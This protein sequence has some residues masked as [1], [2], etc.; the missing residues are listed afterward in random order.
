MAGTASS[1]ELPLHPDFG[2]LAR[3]CRGLL[4]QA[5]EQ[6]IE[7]RCLPIGRRLA[8]GNQPLR[9][10]T[11]R[12]TESLHMDCRS[13]QDYPSR[14]TR[15]PSVRF[16]PLACRIRSK[17]TTN[18][19]VTPRWNRRSAAWLRASKKAIE[20]RRSRKKTRSRLSLP[21]RAKKER[22]RVG[23]RT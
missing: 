20:N 8:S 16:H 6:A 15:A 10:R 12:R 17:H 11:Q 9:R 14:Q 1:L 2:I 22:Q 19:L 7:T 3:R 5:H 4:C 21:R 18:R 23:S 13:R